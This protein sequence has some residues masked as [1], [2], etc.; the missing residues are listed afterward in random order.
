MTCYIVDNVVDCYDPDCCSSAACKTA[1]FCQLAP[2]PISILQRKPKLSAMA[3]FYDTKKFLIEGDDSEGS[4]QRGANSR[5]F[6]PRYNMMHIEDRSFYFEWKSYP[7]WY[8]CSQPPRKNLVKGYIL[9]LHNLLDYSMQ[10]CVTG[11]SEYS[12]TH[13]HSSDCL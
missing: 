12:Y 6:H 5:I 4:I 3:S 7:F 8:R 9:N 2:E 1:A 10:Y 13:T 11:T